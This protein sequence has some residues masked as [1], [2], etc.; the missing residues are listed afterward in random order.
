MSIRIDVVNF[1]L[2]AIGESELNSI[3]DN[4]DKARVMKT[5][6]YIARD[7][8]LEEAEW[9][10]AIRRF[11]PAKSNLAPEW[12]WSF[13]YLIPSDIVRVTAVDRD[14]IGQTVMTD[15]RMQRNQ[16]THVIEYVEGIGRAILTNEDPIFCKGVRRI[17]DEGIYSPLFVEAFSLKLAYLAAL[18]LTQST[19]I[20]KHAMGMYGDAIRKA[21]SRDAMQ[22][23]TRRV[24]S[25]SLKRA[26]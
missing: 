10:F 15:T 3:E 17:E 1:G 16:I 20:Q 6:Y 11:N 2:G 21:K 5:F 8:V 7:S 14:F 13:A 9:T 18:P 25:H 22:S 26:R 4:S 23:T 19:A 12:G 24:T